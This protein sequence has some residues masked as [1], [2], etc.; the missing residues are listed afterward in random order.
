MPSPLNPP[1][2]CRFHPRCAQATERCG[3]EDPVLR[4]RGVGRWWLAIWRGRYCFFV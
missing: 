3:V 4:E 1:L 2:G